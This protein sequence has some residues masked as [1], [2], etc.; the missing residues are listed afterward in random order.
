MTRAFLPAL[1]RA[2]ATAF[3]SCVRGLEDLR[4][5]FT[6]FLRR[7]EKSRHYCR[8]LP[9]NL[10]VGNKHSENC[11]THARTDAVPHA[12]E[13]RAPLVLLGPPRASA[14][15]PPRSNAEKPS[16][17]CILLFSTRHLADESSCV[18]EYNDHILIYSVERHS[19]N[20]SLPMDVDYKH[21]IWVSYGI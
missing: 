12:P 14:P 4:I 13:H 1:R 8:K 15:T 6:A 21:C 3:P 20:S 7:D 5:I 16:Q 9:T 2:L 19:Y 17:S 10:R 18:V 11:S